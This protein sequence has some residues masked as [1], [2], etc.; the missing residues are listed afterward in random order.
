MDL[1]RAAR[2]GSHMD[3]GLLILVSDLRGD[4]RSPG[5]N[6]L[7]LGEPTMATG[8]G[9]SELVQGTEIFAMGKDFSSESSL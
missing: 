1:V 7:D 9:R 4:A 3:M 5:Q 8:A 6:A 2:V